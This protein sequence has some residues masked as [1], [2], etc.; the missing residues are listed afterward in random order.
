MPTSLE[1]IKAILEAQLGNTII[2]TI[3]MGRKKQVERK[4]ILTEIY[5][6]VFVVALDQSEHAFERVSYSYTDI[7]TNTVKIHFLS[8]TC[9][10][11]SFL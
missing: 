11:V 4:G 8:N 2:L 6:S 7:L 10:I 5:P 1:Q 9:D 3:Q